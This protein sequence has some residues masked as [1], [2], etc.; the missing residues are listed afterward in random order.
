M[1]DLRILG[2]S[3]VALACGAAIGWEREKAGKWAG[4]RTHMLVCFAAML[5]GSLA[6]LL[7]R[8]FAGQLPPGA[9]RSD[10][11]RI[12]EAVATGI[13]FI[14]A[15]T[16]FRD[17]SGKGMQGLTTAATLLTVAPIGI[18]VAA[19]RYILAAGAT[20][21]VIVVLR[22]ILRLEERLG[23]SPPHGSASQLQNGGTV[24]DQR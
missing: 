3:L 5:F 18:A 1:E 20:V 16:V 14:A 10:P 17:R 8:Q 22:V 15:G 21:L 4:L 7:I 12:M 24:E 2:Q 9:A 19:H 13:S 11:I 6:E 23:T